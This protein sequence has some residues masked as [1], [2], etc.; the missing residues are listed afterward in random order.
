MYHL[1]KKQVPNPICQFMCSFTPSYSSE[2]LV[3]CG[4]NLRGKHCPNM[5]KL[6]RKALFASVA[7]SRNPSSL[8]ETGYK[9]SDW[10]AYVQPCK[11]SSWHWGGAFYVKGLM[12]NSRCNL[13][14]FNHNHVVH[15]TG[16]NV[17]KPFEAAHG[18]AT[19]NYRLGP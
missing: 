5:M 13:D 7:T 8:L 1:G 14:V 10:S 11:C 19:T 6:C 3:F 4:E 15:C 16:Q 17:P 2:S 12:N 9:F 18:H